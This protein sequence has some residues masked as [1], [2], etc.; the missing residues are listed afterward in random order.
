MAFLDHIDPGN[1]GGSV[2]TPNSP[3]P[4]KFTP[5]VFT[6]QIC[7]E[8][9]KS[10]DLM[11]EHRISEHPVKRP[12]LLINGQPL[13]KEK[14]TVRSKIEPGSISFQDVDQV[15]VDDNLVTDQIQVIEWLCNTSPLVFQL[16]LMN[17]NY[18]VV[19]RWS[20]DIAD[21]DELDVV[22]GQFYNAFD[23]GLEIS[24]AFGLF[25][26]RVSKMSS[27]ARNYA[28]GLSCY[29]TAVLTKDQ[30]P[31]ATLE[32]DKYI[33]KLGESL[34]ILDD[35]RDRPLPKAIIVIAEFMQN[36]FNLLLT[37][38]SLP[39]LDST[40]RFFNSG[41][42]IEL[43]S[44]DE[45]RKSI[46][47]DNVTNEIVN[48]C[49]CTDSKRDVLLPD[50][51]K[52][53]QVGSTNNLDRVKVLFMLWSFYISKRDFEKAKELRGKLIHNQYFG[54]IVKVIEDSKND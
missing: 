41:R 24:A 21:P 45:Q 7:G 4:K 27:A 16:R 26:E 50:I 2:P 53:L 33:D 42:F 35:Y 43:E 51:E 17:Q 12:M 54:G 28:A 23:T 52:L 19:Y 1:S 15:Y 31:G 5:I 10:Q 40:K 14:I 29:V 47:V 6:C 39:K 38:Q 32:Y 36:N 22:D 25:N 37:D 9:F 49:A 11:Q 8:L 3:F 13:R 20:I 46:P 30:L 48:F 34:D 18:P 44:I